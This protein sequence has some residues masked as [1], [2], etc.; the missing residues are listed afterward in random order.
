[1]CAYSGYFEKIIIIWNESSVMENPLLFLMDFSLLSPLEFFV[2]P[3]NAD[4]RNN[5][6]PAMRVRVDSL[7]FPTMMV[8]DRIAMHPTIL[9]TESGSW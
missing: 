9:R 1:M 5:K 4:G 6:S 7:L 3:K 8:A 2:D